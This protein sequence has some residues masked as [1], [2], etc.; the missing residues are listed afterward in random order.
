MAYD[1]YTNLGSPDVVINNVVNLA[2]ANGWTTERNGLAGSNRTATLRK[3][4]V[5]DYVHL[6]NTDDTHI[7]MRI[8]IGYDDALAPHLQ[9][10]VSGESLTWLG[11]GPYPKTFVFLSQDQVWATIG[12]AASG[13]YRHFTFGRVDKAGAYDGGTYVDGTYWLTTSH[14]ASFG[15][16]HIPFQATYMSDPNPGRLR[17]D[18]P[19]DSRVNWF[20][21]IGLDK[22]VAAS[23]VYG[24]AGPGTIGG[25]VGTAAALV[26]LADKNAFSGRS[27]FHTLPLYVKRIG[28]P[29]YWSLLGT[30]QDIRYCSLNKFEP[31]QEVTIGTD[32]WKVFPVVAKRPVTDSPAGGPAGSGDYGYAIKKVL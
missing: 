3:A 14:A 23:V 9:P 27:I 10:N 8:S 1:L 26:L 12:V 28:A 17:A 31:E 13:E 25:D 24:E 22:N 18:I 6:Y 15:F 19:D 20:H 7:R 5:S 32:V 11:E 21:D 16:K 29:M 4:G 30:V 2:A